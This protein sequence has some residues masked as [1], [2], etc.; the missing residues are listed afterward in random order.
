MERWEEVVQR[1]AEEFVYP[2]TPDLTEAV[3]QRLGQQSSHRWSAKQLMWTAAAVFLAAA[4]AI[5]LTP[6]ARAAVLEL[7]RLGA[8]RI[9]QMEIPPVPSAATRTPA[10]TP[11]DGVSVLDLAGKT[12]LEDAQRR[13][14]FALRAPAY[15]EDL[16]RPDYVFYQFLQGPAVILVWLADDNPAVV[17]MSLFQLGPGAMVHKGEPLVLTET[18]VNGQRALWTQGPY[19]VITGNNQWDFRRLIDGHVLIWTE[20]AITYRLETWLSMEEA[21]R[22]AESLVELP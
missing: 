2:P 17:E 21:V 19:L 6:Q 3:A 20:A 8:V 22:V 15:P 16:G 9:F 1:T 5:S 10:P 12:T 13:A 14:G 11:V 18:S 7:V 4:L